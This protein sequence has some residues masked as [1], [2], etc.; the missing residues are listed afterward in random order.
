MIYTL[1]SIN[2]SEVMPPGHHHLS[3]RKP[4][5][6]TSSIRSYPPALFLDI[7]LGV[8]YGTIRE[9]RIT[10]ADGDH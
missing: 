8:P 4:N 7:P 6:N 2:S 3:E 1:F 10:V 5:K 9:R